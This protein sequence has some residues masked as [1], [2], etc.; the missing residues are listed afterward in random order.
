M[1]VIVVGASAGGVRALKELVSKIPADI[2]AAVLVVMHVEPSGPGLLPQILNN[3]GPL[4]SCHPKSGQRVERG[5]VYVAPPDFHM[6]V[7]AQGHIRLSRGA[8][9]NRTRPAIDPLFRSA[10]LA[11]GSE[12]IGVVLTGYLT[13]GTA[14]LFAIKECG[15]IAVVQDPSDAEVPS[16]PANAIQH[17]AVDHCVPLSELA[18]LLVRLTKEPTKREQ[19]AMTDPLKIE[20][21]IMENP[22]EFSRELLKSGE[23]SV[24][25]CPECHG[26]LL[27]LRDGH[28][29]RFRC[30]TGHGF[31]AQS[32]LEGL[33][34]E[35]EAVIWSAVRT[36]QESALL[37]EHLAQ[38]AREAGREDDAHALLAEAQERLKRAKIL[39]T[40]II[41]PGR[42]ST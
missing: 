39:R 16:M 30:H 11:F 10:A 32:L 9:E 33:D 38:H 34:E 42:M 31:S 18:S 40:T 7:D 13:D 20:T 19:P 36:L 4:P 6:L 24:W 26:T 15:G 25:T 37:R 8:K 12:V 35:T 5:H 29:V 21:K 28:L 23:P 2:D 17:A 1:R 27:K 22:E 41:E 14:G 3:A